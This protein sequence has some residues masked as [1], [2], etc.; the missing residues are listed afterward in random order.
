MEPLHAGQSRCVAQLEINHR[1][2][3]RGLIKQ[4]FELGSALRHPHAIAAPLERTLQRTGKG[5]IVLH[6]H[7]AAGRVHHRSVE[8]SQVS[9]STSLTSAPPSALL[10]AS[11]RP[12]SRRAT[13]A[14]RNSPSPCP[15]PLL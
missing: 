12:P 13:L 11:S 15:A 8:G 4:G 10:A 1:E 6:D 14:A 2:A 9:G 5:A 7:K 3:G